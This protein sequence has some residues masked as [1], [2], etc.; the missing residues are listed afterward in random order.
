MIQFK[1]KSRGDVEGVGA[2]VLIYPV[3]QAADV[4]LYRAHGVPVGEDQRQHIELM[5]DI[6]LRF[7]G[8]FGDTFVVPEAWIP[9]AGARIMA[10]DS[11]TEKMSKS[12]GRPNASILLM[13]P[14]ERVAKKIKSAVTDS[15]RDIVASAEKPAITN[16][17]TMFSI[18]QDEPIS[19]LE[20]RFRGAGY[21]E[22]K[23]SLADAVVERLRPIRERYEELMSDP[24]EMEKLLDVGAEKARAVAETTMVD[25]W[26]RVGLG[27]RP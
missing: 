19:H 13:E 25:V 26:A 4:L 15:G 1:E 11:P 27:A 6:A 8:T 3:L 9:P 2:G 16:L 20:E 7:N 21:A 10:L 18:V 24:A 22:F 23:Q 17:L 12:A 5:R 14:P